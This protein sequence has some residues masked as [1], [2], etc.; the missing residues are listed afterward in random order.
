M[1]INQ[2]SKGKVSVGSLVVNGKTLTGAEL[3]AVDGVTAGTVTASKAVIVDSN[4]DIGDFR[5][6]D[7][8]N[9]DAGASGTAGSVDVFPTTASKG[10]LSI[11][12]AD[13]TGNTATTIVNAEQAGARTYTIPD[14]GASASFLMT[15]GDQTLGDG[16]DI[17]VGT[18][19]G[20]KIGTG[21]T[22]KLGFFGAT[23]VVQQS[24][25][26]QTYSTADRT[27]AS[28]TASALTVTDG[29]GTN[30]NTIGAI[31]DNASTIAAVQ[32]L[33]D[34]INKL[35]ADVADI[36]QLVN[37]VIDDLQALGFVA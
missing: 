26:T 19:T 24:A 30:D 22:Q 7:A 9:V 29:A 8:V 20:T 1:A 11:T 31:T 23:P 10:K 5:N 2:A 13:S 28:P 35:V 4:K 33:A 12:A 6:L 3:D 34:E 32:E 14:A 16:K 25:Y 17:A 36:K 18:T 21:S 37:S 15:E 27:H